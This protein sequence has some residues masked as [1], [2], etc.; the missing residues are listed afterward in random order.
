MD[1]KHVPFQIGTF[2]TDP[3]NLI[4]VALIAVVAIVFL[5]GIRREVATFA[6]F[7]GVIGAIL[8]S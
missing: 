5:F 6:I 7:A 1:L 4:P 3:A 2:S 8:A